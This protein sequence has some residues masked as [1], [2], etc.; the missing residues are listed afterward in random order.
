MKQTHCDAITHLEALLI[1]SNEGDHSSTVDTS[2]PF[3]MISYITSTLCS[4][5]L[6]MTENP[7]HPSPM[8]VRHRTGCGAPYASMKGA[9]EILSR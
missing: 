9:V 8:A 1:I 5:S 2:S 7:L 3:T 4:S 6:K